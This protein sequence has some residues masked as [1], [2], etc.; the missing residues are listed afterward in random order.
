MKAF[1]EQFTAWVDGQLAGEELAAF[2]RELASRPDALAERAA[3]EKL[4]ALLRR[5]PTAPSLSNPEFFSLQLLQRIEA[6]QPKAPRGPGRASSPW[7][8]SLPRLAMAGAA[9]LLVALVL[10]RATI[11]SSKPAHSG[12]PYFAQVIESWPADESLSATT[13]YTPEDNV[14]VLWIDGLDSVPAEYAIQ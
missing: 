2:E 11:P 5:Q 6:G 4:R 12:A 14:T 1:E 3:A 10:F 13:L 7:F 9:C 8:W